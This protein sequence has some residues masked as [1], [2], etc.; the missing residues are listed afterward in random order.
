V[1]YLANAATFLIQVAFGFFIGLF[2]VR[3]LLIAVGASFYDPIC[4]FVYQLTNP[5]IT[6]LR[7]FVPRW[8]RLEIASLLVAWVLILIELALFVAIAGASIGVGGLLLR[9]AVSLLDWLIW[10]ALIALFARAILSFVVSEHNNPSMQLLVQCTEPLVR[11]FRRIVPPLGGLD[12]SL[13]FAMIALTLAQ[14]LIIAPL[15]D[16]A[17]HG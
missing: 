16:L 4:R 9:S 3:V 14:I 10:I 1:N 15:N 7:R 5:V 17:A 6:P 8:R 2:L 12:F 11:P 13:M